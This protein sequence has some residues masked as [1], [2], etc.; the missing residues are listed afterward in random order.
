MARRSPTAR[1]ASHGGFHSPLLRLACELSGETKVRI[2]ILTVVS[3]LA[4]C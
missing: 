2:A 3:Y 1:K 4:L